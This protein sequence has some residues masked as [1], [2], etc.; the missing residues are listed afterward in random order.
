MTS[1][2]ET[3][4][5][6]E[7]AAHEADRYT[8]VKGGEGVEVP[9]RLPSAKTSYDNGILFAWRDDDRFYQNTMDELKDTPVQVVITDEAGQSEIKEMT[10]KEED[11]LFTY[12]ATDP[13]EGTYR[14]YCNVL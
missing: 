8:K 12:H 1:D 6:S 3:G 7:H 5:A 4:D 9:Y 2:E 11:E 13:E 14:F 10:Y